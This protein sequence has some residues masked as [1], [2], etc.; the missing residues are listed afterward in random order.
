MKRTLLIVGIALLAL[1]A[2]LLTTGLV[3]FIIP[4]TFESVAKIALPAQMKQLFP[5]TNSSDSHQLSAEME[6]LQSQSTLSQVITNLDLNRMWGEK[7]KEGELLI[8]LTCKLLSNQLRVRPGR[9]T[10][11]VEVH[12]RSDDP[13]EAATIANNIAEVYRNQT[14]RT[15]DMQ[16][17]NGSVSEIRDPIVQIIDAAEPNF[18]PVKPHPLMKILVPVAGLLAGILGVVLLMLS[19]LMRGG[20][21]SP[22][23]LPR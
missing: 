22:P 18:R 4:P 2:V 10:A 17:N 15:Q 11:I 13:T 20:K 14:A 3:Q 19:V 9:G 6:K 1:S 7:F 8:D 21:K 12:V 23:S 5:G 16:R